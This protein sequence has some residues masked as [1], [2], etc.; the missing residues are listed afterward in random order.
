MRLKKILER[1]LLILGILSATMILLALTP[2]P[3]Y[4]HHS[5]GKNGDPAENEDFVPQHIILMGGAGMPSESNLMR[6]YYCASLSA[7]HNC[8]V[9]IVLPSDS[10]CHS[11]MEDFLVRQGVTNAIYHD[12]I[13]TNTRSQVLGLKENYA[14]LLDIPIAVVSSPEHIR[15]TIKCLKKEGFTKVL[16][17]PA[18]EGTVNFD[19]TL[20]GQHLYGNINMPNIENTKIRYTFW[21]YLKLEIVVFREYFALAYYKIKGWI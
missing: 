12:T 11:K 7:V 21:N 20:E 18:S 1:S 16:G 13:G 10:A 17:V 2:I 3:F 6:L 19:L 4:L 9:T 15:R 5:L 8:P 14:E